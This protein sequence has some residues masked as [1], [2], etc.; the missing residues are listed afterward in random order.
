MVRIMF[1]FYKSPGRDTG[2]FIGMILLAI[3]L[4]TPASAA[5]PLLSGEGGT[6]VLQD[7]SSET[8]IS[9]VEWTEATPHAE[10]ADRSGHATVVFNDR[11]WVIGGWHGDYSCAGESCYNDIWSSG[12]GIHWRRETEHAAFGARYAHR[13]V[14]FNN[15]IWLIGGRNTT[16]WD[17]SNDV[18]YSADG[19]HWT[20]AVEHAPFAPRADFALTVFKNELWVIGGTED[21]PVYNDVWHSS[22]GV[23]WVPATPHAGFSPRMEPSACVFQDRIW[24]T[25]GFDWNGIYNDLWISENGKDWTRVME[26]APFP[27]RRYQNM[28]AAD[29]KLWVIGGAGYDGHT[30]FNDVWFTHDGIMWT[31]ASGNRT[32]PPRYSFTTAVFRDRL[33]VI[34]GTSG[35]DIWFSEPFSSPEPAVSATGGPGSY[36]VVVRKRISPESLKQGTDARITITVFNGGTHPIHDIEVLDEIRPEFPVLDGLTRYSTGLIEPDGTRILTYTVRAVKAGSFRLNRTMLMFAGEDGNY[37][38]LYSN[39]ENVSVLPPLLGSVREDN[40]RDLLHDLMAWFNR[41]S[42]FRAG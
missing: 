30:L 42:P 21:G 23:S 9:P 39:Y 3:L 24:V 11:L 7:T 20:R 32:F 35:N 28:E 5:T 22:D 19:T 8:R 36:G 38:I 17:M 15:R 33:W 29:G 1:C 16:S 12:D 4:T 25:G 10:F 18:W 26:H 40:P 34:A 27:A 14:V 2:V 31:Q 41:I 13:A 6:A 37:R